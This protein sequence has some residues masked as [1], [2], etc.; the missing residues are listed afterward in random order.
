[1]E[2]SAAIVTKKQMSAKPKYKNVTMMDVDISYPQVIMREDAQASVPINRF[3]RS[4]AQRYYNYALPTL[5]GSAV[6]EYQ[7]DR[8][9]GYPFRPY[10]AMMVYEVPYNRNG[11][12]SIYY[13]LY[14]YTGGAHGNTT[15]YSD[16]WHAGRHLKLQDLFTGNSY[17]SIIFSEIFAQINQNIA[18]GT[19]TYFDDYQKNVFQN[20]DEKNFYL[21]P[22]GLA[23]YFP[24]YTV[25]PYSSG[26]VTFV[27]PYGA[28]GATL[29]D[30]DL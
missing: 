6:K 15:R 1:M 30:R 23:V 13:E 29:K 4:V 5:F 22:E 21:T 27:I 9:N 10:S 8:K 3:Y 18:A 14:E 28:F 16:T 7:N 19:D 20:F 12:L 26:I 2:Q 25:A 24:L 17:K 11:F